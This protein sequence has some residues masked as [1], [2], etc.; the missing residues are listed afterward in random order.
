KDRDLCSRRMNRSGPDE[1]ELRHLRVLVALAQEGTFTD[2]AIEV[3]LSQPAVSR[4]LA[5]LETLIGVDLVSRTTRSLELTPAG[6][7]ALPAA[8]TA[9]EA[10]DSFVEA[11]RGAGLRV[12]LGYTW[13]AFGR[14]TDRILQLWRGE[15]PDMPIEIHRIDDRAAGL[16]RGQVDVAI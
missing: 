6:Q 12:R 9:L 13:A 16:D 10:V 8:L 7:A 3:G 11:A 15:H 1:L 14:H 5:R 2:A 4:C